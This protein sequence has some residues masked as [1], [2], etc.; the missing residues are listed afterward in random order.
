MG[1]ALLDG[2]AAAGEEVQVVER[3][4]KRRADLQDQGHAVI[5]VPV[6]CDGAIIAVKPKDVELAVGDVASAGAGRLLSIAAG[7]TSL[8]LHRWAGPSIPVIRA[9]PNLGAVVGRSASAM[10]AGPGAHQA[11]LDWADHVLSSVGSVVHVTED[12]MDA[13]TGLAGS[14]PAY[15][16]LIAEAL[17]DAGV[18]AGLPYESAR[19]LTIETMS[20]A[21]E[22][23]SQPDAVPSQLRAN[24]TTPAGTT[25]AG[26][27]LLEQ[28]GLRAGLIDAVAAATERSHQLGKPVADA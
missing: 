1:A 4:P 28:R 25:A 7:I 22:L 20:G 23:L 8:Q 19:K 13:V 16:F 27:R 26:L 11:D 17:I 15:F 24:V 10:C 21:A 5:E 6:R 14:G 3:D 2:L 18:S 12:Q 9:M